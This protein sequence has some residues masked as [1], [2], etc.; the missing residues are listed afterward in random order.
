MTA[1]N[2]NIFYVHLSSWLTLVLMSS[3]DSEKHVFLPHSPNNNKSNLCSP[4]MAFKFY[5]L[6]KYNHVTSLLPSLWILPF[7]HSQIDGVFFS[8][9]LLFQMCI[10]VLQGCSNIRRKNM[11]ER[12]YFKTQRK[13][14]K[15]WMNDIALESKKIREH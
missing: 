6:I 10:C 9:V 5:I 3:C 15:K 14:N 12:N 13:G 2:F 1:N 7:T 8:I 4:M 11:T